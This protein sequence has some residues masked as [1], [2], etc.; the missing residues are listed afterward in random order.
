MNKL[1]LL[2]ALV[3]TSMIAVAGTPEHKD[4]CK[5]GKALCCGE[6]CCKA[7]DNCCK[8]VEHKAC[9]MECKELPATKP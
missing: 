4:C 8:G 1:F 6:T 3:S 5:P 2:L 7:A 9:K